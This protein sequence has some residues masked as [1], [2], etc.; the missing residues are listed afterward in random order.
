MSLLGEN[1]LKVLQP[2]SSTFAAL[3]QHADHGVCA[4]PGV[5][6]S[7]CLSPPIHSMVRSAWNAEGLGC[8]RHSF[9]PHLV[10]HKNHERFCLGA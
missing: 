5:C 2:G 8:S 9:R 7:A 10:P 1:V 6:V 4:V 3:L